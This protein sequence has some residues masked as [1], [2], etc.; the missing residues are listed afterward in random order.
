MS[1]HVVPDQQTNHITTLRIKGFKKFTGLT[2]DFNPNVNIIV[3]ENGSGKSTILEAIKVV[4]NQQNKNSDRSFLED[5]FNVEAKDAFQQNPCI[6]TLP[7]I[8]IE[9]E[10]SLNPSNTKSINFHGEYHSQKR[11]AVS[12]KS[13][14]STE[15][16][17]ER[18]GIT[19]RCFYDPTDNEDLD[20]F[21]EEGNI[22]YEHYTMEWTTF[23]HLAY[24]A[25]KSPINI[26]SINTSEQSTTASFNQYNRALFLS[27]YDEKTIANAK[28][29]F[30]HEINR[31]FNN[32]ELREIDPNSK[33]GIDNKKVILERIISIYQGN[34]LLEN[35][36]GGQANLIKTK[37]ALTKSN[38]VDTILIEEPENHLSPTTLNR[39]ISDI[40]KKIENRQIIITTHS[41]TIASRLNLNNVLWI[42]GEKMQSLRDIKKETARFFEKLPSN[43]FLTLLLSRKS[44]LV[45]GPTEYLLLPKLYKKINTSSFEDDE[46]SI[47]SCNGITYQRYL[48]IAEKT[49]KKVLVLT[50]NDKKTKNIKNKR[51]T[52]DNLQRVYMSADEE[53]WTWEVCFYKLNQIVLDKL[54]ADKIKDDK[55]DSETDLTQ[56]S[57][58]GK[59]I[60][61]TLRWMLKNKTEAAYKMLS[62]QDDE[63]EVP[64]Y[65]QE[66]LRWIKE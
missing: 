45:E 8:E 43:S 42:A 11:E 34:I 64:K 13:K 37:I 1:T 16:S 60:P 46:I 28:N 44:I 31:A 62:L 57:A 19:F 32:L 39:M 30:R 41:N 50:D 59:N 18:Y 40:E 61:P 55:G 26:I 15:A 47:I 38:N 58:I 17:K 10:L 3:G 63:I 49:K 23:A 24:H 36:G 48:D 22:P 20:A 2:V 66:A 25:T 54:F 21:I 14:I 7:K 53:E 51:K 29:N 9:V 33:F 56:D 52:T 6:E 35:L 12:N 5:W 4:L 65:I 27:N